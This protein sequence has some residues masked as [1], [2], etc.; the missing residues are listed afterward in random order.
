M[1]LHI[2]G[3]DLSEILIK[4]RYPRSFQ[5]DQSDIVEQTYGDDFFFGTGTV[6][7]IYFEGIHIAYGDL[8]LI[9]K[10]CLRFESEIK[11][12]EMH[13]ALS[14]Q[15]LSRSPNF[16]EEII[17]GS[18]QHNIVYVDGFNGIIEW[19]GLNNNMA[20]LEI[21]LLPHIFEKYLPEGTEI[22]E[23]FKKNIDRNNTSSLGSQNFPISPQMLMIIREITSCKREGIFKKIFLKAKVIELLL[24]QL[25]QINERHSQ[26]P[27]SIKKTDINKMHAVKEILLNNLDQSYTLDDLALKAG[28]NA[29]TLKKGFKEIFGTTVFDFWHDIKM[30]QAR[31]MLLEEGLAVYE[32]SEQVGY[33]YPQHFTTAFKKKFGVVPS[34]L[35]T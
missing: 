24:L 27:Y 26:T 7:E 30:Q 11:T 19:S 6:H 35:K 9:H 8:H 18:N 20:F 10:T 33:K 2:H 14:G 17:F 31:K 29:F 15:S 28:T 5:D 3:Q 4:N 1:K 13:F 23:S 16:K 12:V 21:N 32:V 34:D 25:E 22:F